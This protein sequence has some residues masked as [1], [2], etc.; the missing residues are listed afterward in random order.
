MRSRRAAWV[1]APRQ[2]L[3][4]IGREAGV[5]ASAAAVAD[6]LSTAF[7]ISQVGDIEAY[8]LKRPEVEVWVLE[9]EL[10]HF[11][12]TGRAGSV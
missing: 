2:V 9:R 7:I 10:L 12:A 4:E 8:C 6:A 3:A 5:E 1:S 11:P